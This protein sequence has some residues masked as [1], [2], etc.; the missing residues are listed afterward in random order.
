MKTIAGDI[1]ASV[2]QARKNW[3][4]YLALGILL[5]LVGFYAIWAG[6]A[7]TIASIIVLGIVLL[8]AG[9]GQLIGAFMMRG[10]G[11]IILALL[12]GVLDIVVGLILIGHPTLGALTITLFLAVLFVF[13]GIFRFV[14][15]LWLQYPQ[16]GWAAASGFVTF[17]LGVLL[18]AQWPISAV[19][20]PGF[21]VGVN[22]IFA[23]VA[24]AAMALRLKGSAPA[25]AT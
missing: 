2:D 19:W 9:V 6:E 11:H 21:A 4:W 25:L 7:A 14:S 8:I 18:W 23:G 10:A 3:G 12:V 16:Y 5:I 22:F 24:W 15:A 17:L 13:A 20:F 1:A